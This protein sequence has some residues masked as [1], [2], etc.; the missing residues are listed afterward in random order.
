M[1]RFLTSGE[2]HGKAIIS[3]LE[4]IPSNLQIDEEYINNELFFRQ[5]TY[6]RGER[7]KIEKDR[8]EIISGVRNGKTTG[9][10]IAILIPNKDYENWKEIMSKT[11]NEK[12][13]TKNEVTIPRPGHADLSGVIKYNLNDIRDVIERASARETVGR[14]SAGAI[15]KKFLA[16]FDIE[17]LGMTIKIG[18]IQIKTQNVLNRLSLESKSKLRNNPSFPHLTNLRSFSSDEIRKLRK[19]VNKSPLRCLDKDKEKEMIKLIDSTK[20]EGDTLGGE[21]ALITSQLPIGLGSFIQWDKKLDGKIAQAIMSI[22]SV[23]GVEIGRGF[24]GAELFG[25]QMNDE[26][27]IFQK[28]KM[29]NQ[30]L[31]SQNLN[32]QIYRKTNNAGGIEGGMTNGESIIIKAAVKPVPT[33]RK[34]L[35]SI[36]LKTKKSV[37]ARYERSDICI[38]PAASVIGESMLSIVLTSEILEKFGGDSMEEIYSRFSSSANKF[39]T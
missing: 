6:G 19:I 7:M 12:L 14:V 30:K 20:E 23:K 18:T 1:L 10:P 27:F 37:T 17:I 16:E 5:S 22:P 34:P 11:K 29:R 21:F 15:C 33:L 25:S 32:K 26:I 2:S 24:E 13:R 8:A 36:D 35:S 28:S 38:V 9:A 4:G 3:I 39:L 31:N